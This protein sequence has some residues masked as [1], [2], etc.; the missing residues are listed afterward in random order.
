M[1]DVV[2]PA[3]QQ[4][5]RECRITSDED[6]WSMYGPLRG[7]SEQMAR[8]LTLVRAARHHGSGGV[9]LVTGP[10]GIG[11]TALVTE[12]RRQ[13][14]GLKLRVAGGKCDEGEQVSPGA[15][16]IALLR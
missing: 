16:V 15:P 14:V 3:A 1:R 9:L 10:A 5:W 4:N 8:A 2:R 6:S 7:R 11:K 13:S 12:V